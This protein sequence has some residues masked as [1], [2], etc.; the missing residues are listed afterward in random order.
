MVNLV[1]FGWTR[2]PPPEPLPPVLGETAAREE[3]P[4]R[5]APTKPLL[6]TRLGWPS[7]PPSVPP[8][9]HRD[10]TGPQRFRRRSAS[11]PVGAP[12]RPSPCRTRGA[13][14]RAEI[15]PLARPFCP[16]YRGG[17]P[18]NGPFKIG[19]MARRS[20]GFSTRNRSPCWHPDHCLLPANR[21][22]HPLPNTRRRKL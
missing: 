6:G 18:K 21:R 17:M 1:S 14:T 19:L 15:G 5:K 2:K 9:N 8:N 11:S 12:K 13:H 16:Y 7:Y 22:K 20:R 10:G 3:P 4:R